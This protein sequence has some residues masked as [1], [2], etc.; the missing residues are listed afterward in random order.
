MKTLLLVIFL[1][2]FSLFAREEVLSPKLCYTHGQYQDSLPEMG[3]KCFIVKSGMNPNGSP[4]CTLRCPQMP[5]GSYC[6]TVQGHVFGIC[7]KEFY[8][9]PA[10]DPNNC[11]NAVDVDDL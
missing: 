9:V 10:F 1:S 11:S 2:S 7:K 5:L 3:F 4:S 6:E 8:Q